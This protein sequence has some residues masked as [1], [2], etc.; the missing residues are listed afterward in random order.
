MILFLEDYL[1]ETV[2]NFIM[3]SQKGC[4][5]L[6]HPFLRDGVGVIGMV[7]LMRF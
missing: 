4:C 3:K 7:I 5:I 2:D 6:Q 1:A